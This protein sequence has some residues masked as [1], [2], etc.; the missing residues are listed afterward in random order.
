[1]VGLDEKTLCFFL[2]LLLFFC[3]LAV[4]ADEIELM[5]QEIETTEEIEIV[6]EIVEAPGPYPLMEVQLNYLLGEEMY[7]GTL[8]LR[9]NKVGNKRHY[10]KR[11]KKR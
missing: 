3:P 9:D 8:D 7:F 2:A 5:P 6:E 4:Q 1:M 10:S 11:K